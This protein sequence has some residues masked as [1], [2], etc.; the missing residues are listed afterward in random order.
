[1]SKFILKNFHGMF[2]NIYHKGMSWIRILAGISPYGSDFYNTK[3]VPR[4]RLN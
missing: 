3:P 1:M 2:L 4:H